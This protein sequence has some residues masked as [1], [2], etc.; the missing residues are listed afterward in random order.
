VTFEN[1]RNLDV[2]S[3][4]LLIGI[5]VFKEWDE[6]NQKPLLVITENMEIIIPKT[7]FDHPNG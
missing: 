6:E 2:V 7:L 1:L 4:D 5:Q 3:G